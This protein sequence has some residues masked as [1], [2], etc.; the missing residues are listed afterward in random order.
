M[1]RHTHSLDKS[2]KGV[3]PYI[4]LDTTP[5]MVPKHIEDPGYE[6]PPC[7]R[8]RNTETT[9]VTSC[10]KHVPYYVNYSGIPVQCYL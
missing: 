10:G 6:V 3:I 5:N 8:L 7:L 4:D 1:L 2:C 9:M